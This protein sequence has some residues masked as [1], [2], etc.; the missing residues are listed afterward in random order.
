MIATWSITPVLGLAPLFHADPA[1]GGPPVL[2]PD[3]HRR[4]NGDHWMVVGGAAGPSTGPTYLF[5]TPEPTRSP[6]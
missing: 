2:T 3:G 4:W 1:V 5:G 6:A